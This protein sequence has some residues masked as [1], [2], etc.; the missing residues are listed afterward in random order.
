MSDRPNILLVFTDQQR[1]DTIQALGSSFNAQTPTMDFLAQE[2]VSFD[3]CFCTAPICSPSRSTIMTGLY[4][5]QTGMPGNLYAPCPAM[6][7]TIPTIGNVFRN[8]GYETCYHGKWHLGADVKDYGFDHG[9]ES[10]HDESTRLMASR[11]WRDRDWMANERPFCHIVSFINPHDHYF[12]D[13]NKKVTNYK[14]PWK[15][16]D[17]DVSNVPQPASGKMVDW[18]EERWG[19]YDEY[20]CEQIERADKDLGELLH[21][22]RTGGFYN[23]SWII[24][25][26]DH[27]DMAGEHN[28]P[29]KGSYM[30]DGQ[31]RVPLIIIPPMTRFL[32]ADRSGMFKHAIKV[33]Q[34]S[35]GLCSNVDILPT[36]MDIAGIEKPANLPGESLLPQ[37]HGAYEQAAHDCVF[38]EW[39]LPPI[40]M[41]RTKSWKYVH[42]LDQ[43]EELY[44]L[45]ND[46]HECVNEIDNPKHADALADMRTRLE[47][48]IVGIND[49]FNELNKHEFIFNP[50]DNNNP[51]AAV[52]FKSGK[53][54]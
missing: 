47:A 34:R 44:D 19:S 10:T 54:G 40:R 38:A 12:Y 28:L 11:F 25:T 48:H 30:Y 23:N 33:G 43:G 6:N 53:R 21:Q 27:G 15:N 4:P 20:Y 9:E 3:N 16:L 18:S 50:S 29:F 45:E 13:P 8:A 46:P 17:R 51:G 41:A 32:G 52:D 37:V 24:F 1:F 5:S 31:V 22:F 39:H 26:T 7:V 36:M 49:P 14:R 2:G 35:G 42:Y